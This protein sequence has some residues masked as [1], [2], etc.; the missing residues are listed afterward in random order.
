MEVDWSANVN[1][2]TNIMTSVHSEYIRQICESLKTPDQEKNFDYVVVGYS[3]D[4]L[5]N[6][7]DLSIFPV[8]LDGTSFPVNF[9][10]SLY[11]GTD[12][13]V[14][15]GQDALSLRFNDGHNENLKNGQCLVHT[16]QSEH[17]DWYKKEIC[18]ALPVDKLQEVVGKF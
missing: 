1:R 13:K 4:R 18:F 3:Y 2:L 12:G 7:T 8:Y 14:H 11:L 15:L 17:I 5:K 6:Y 10:R 16:D 9:K